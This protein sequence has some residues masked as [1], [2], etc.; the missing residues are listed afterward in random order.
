MPD[1]V[2]KPEVG[3]KATSLLEVLAGIFL[4]LVGLLLIRFGFFFPGALVAVVG[5]VV[6]AF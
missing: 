2:E 1:V 3:A 6:L 4:I 5:L